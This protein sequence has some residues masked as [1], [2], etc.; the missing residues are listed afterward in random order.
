MTLLLDF[1]ILNIFLGLGWYVRQKVKILQKIFMPS[2][3]IGGILLLIAGPQVLNIVPVSDMIKKYPGFLIVVILTC[4]VFGSKL[5]LK[6]FR[7]YADYTVV[8]AGTYGAQLFFGVGIGA[9]L[10]KI[11]VGMPPNWGI[12]TIYSFFA[13]HGAA[14]SAAKIFVDAGYDDF[15]GIAMVVATVGLV[16]ALS[17][18]MPLLNWGIR[19][20]YTE[21]V[22]K[23]EKL[24]DD[25]YG[26]PMPKEKQLPVGMV[27][28]S[29]AGINPIAL[30]M[31]FISLCIMIGFGIR[32]MLV[33]YV[34]EY[35]KNINDIVLGIIGA[36]ILWPLMIKTKKDVYVDKTT[37]SN[38]SG[39][40]L[41]YLIVSA[42][43]TISVEA[44]VSYMVPIAIYC[45]LMLIILTFLYVT[46]CR[47]FCRDEWFEKMVNVFGQC[48]GNAA[49]G[50]T[51]LRCVDPQSQSV[52]GDAS[53]VSLFLFMPVWVGMIALGPVLAM[54][55]NGTI[56]LMAIGLA[57]MVI[58][59]GIGFTVFRKKNSKN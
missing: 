43:G 27:K 35:F 10:S 38:I 25:Y 14:G 13:G 30:Q 3:V 41:E 42:V 39:F 7:S 48:I 1:L 2:S 29:T 17:I 46:A 31:F 47:L 28:T 40:C 33:T 21:F 44:M 11:W 20:G 54:S 50:M 59:Y 23:P 58:F 34:S 49:T 36:I 55:E 56:K 5:N 6:R 51:L 9:I 15:M 22:D 45:I 19:K 24:P 32:W 18:G 8:T 26:G 4:L 57:L 53:G 12:T 52:S 16:A 37:V